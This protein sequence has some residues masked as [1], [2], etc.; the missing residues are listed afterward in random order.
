MKPWMPASVA[1]AAVLVTSLM[2]FNAGAS[3]TKP[4]S[5]KVQ[6]VA[7]T[8]LAAAG[9]LIVQ[10]K[11][12]IE[13]LLISLDQVAAVTLMMK[14]ETASRL[15]PVIVDLAEQTLKLVDNDAI[16]SVKTD[17]ELDRLEVTVGSLMKTMD[18]VIEPEVSL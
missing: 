5:A 12:R 13:R 14:P 3:M 4:V 15:E 1:C 17:N 2:G 18:R 11:L 9:D 16:V 8:K 7:S 6:S 10:R